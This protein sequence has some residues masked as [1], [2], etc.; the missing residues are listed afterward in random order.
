MTTGMIRVSDKTPDSPQIDTISGSDTRTPGGAG[1]ITLV[2]GAM[3]H[4]GSSGNLFF[5]ATRLHMNLPEPGYSLGLAAGISIL[6]GL[7]VLRRRS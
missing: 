6:C 2:G 7:Q 4:G 1:N 3:V 5:N